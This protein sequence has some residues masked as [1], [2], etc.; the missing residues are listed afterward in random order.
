VSPWRV[1]FDA[2]GWILIA[3]VAVVGLAAW[4]HLIAIYARDL[5]DARG[6]PPRI[7]DDATYTTFTTSAPFAHPDSEPNPAARA[8]SPTEET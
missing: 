1:I 5:W 7:Y 3:T 2:T 4:A 6:E 8:P